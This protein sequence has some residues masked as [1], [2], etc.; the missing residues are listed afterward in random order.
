VRDGRD[1]SA[2]FGVC[3]GQGVAPMGLAVVAVGDVAQRLTQEDG[4]IVLLES[5]AQLLLE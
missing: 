3:I 2:P 4:F 1:T 5:G